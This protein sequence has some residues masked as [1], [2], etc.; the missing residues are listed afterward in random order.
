M[1]SRPLILSTKLTVKFTLVVLYLFSISVN[2][3]TINLVNRD[4][5]NE[6]FNDGATPFAN[7]TGNSGST[8]GEQRFNVFRAAADYWEARLISDV[9]ISI[10]I[11]MD[12]LF[13]APFSAT[14]GQ[15]GPENVFRNFENAP[16]AD[17]WYVGAIANSLVGVDLD[18]TGDDI[19]A[20]FNSSID[21]NSNCLGNTNWWLGIDSPAVAGTI[22][23]FDTVL[24][25]IGHGL[26]VLS[27]VNNGILFGGVSDA[28]TRNLYDETTNKFWPAMSN[29]ERIDSSTN[30]GNL[31]WRGFNA[32]TNSGHLTAGKTNGHIRMFAPNPFQPGSSVSHWDTSL[33]PDELMEPLAT[34]TS[35]DRATVQLLKDVGWNIVEGPGEIGFVSAEVSVFEDQGAAILQVE[36]T[37]S[38][39]GAVSV[40]VDSSNLTALGGGVDYNSVVDQ[41]LSWADGEL[42][43]KNV[44]VSV[45]DDQLPE[46]SSET[47]LFSLSN[48]VGGAELTRT[49]TVLT[50][51]EPD[52]DDLLLQVVPAIVGALRRA[53]KN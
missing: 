38:A 26:G 53:K 4:G 8:L 19:G 14:L 6:G 46:P 2:A 33:S 50:I 40:R 7:Q 17:T 36:R 47:A 16:Q 25:E 22:S 29:S 35:D 45:V 52:E 28:Y 49:T 48:V 34:P 41:T 27:L 37:K 9:P 51:R 21:N 12:P 43:T 1:N 18:V 39:Q 15:A 5:P 24:H 13:C 32:D 20:T 30:T 3:A 31:V 44:I 42:G 23:L 11:N 10:G